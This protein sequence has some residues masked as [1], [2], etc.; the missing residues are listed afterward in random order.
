[1]LIPAGHLPI[2]TSGELDVGAGSSNPMRLAHGMDVS[3]LPHEKMSVAGPGYGYHPS[4]VPS[5]YRGPHY[6]PYFPSP[7]LLNHSYQVT[8]SNTILEV[9]IGQLTTRQLVPC[10]HIMNIQIHT[11]GSRHSSTIIAN[12]S[13]GGTIGTRQ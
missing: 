10:H 7:R 5:S 9:T 11:C 12:N 3:R 2:P 8:L 13:S 6:P 4:S 1:M